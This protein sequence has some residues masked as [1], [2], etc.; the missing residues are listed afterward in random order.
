MADRYELGL[1]AQGKI[2]EV[3]L[4]T[5]PRK[6]VY[7]FTRHCHVCGC[8]EDQACINDGVA[9][10][11]IGPALCSACRDHPEAADLEIYEEHL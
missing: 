10:H 3:S 8:T 9:C 2:T 1:D 4:V 5:E 7:P 11:W 6:M